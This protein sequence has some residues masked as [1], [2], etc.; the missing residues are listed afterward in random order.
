ME[1][2]DNYNKAVTEL[3]KHL[4]FT[5]GGEWLIVDCSM[6]YWH[7]APDMVIYSRLTAFDRSEAFA[8]RLTPHRFY[9]VRVFGG[10]KLTALITGNPP[11]EMLQIFDNSKYVGDA[12]S[13]KIYV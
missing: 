5:M 11:N 1:L 8:S 9:D 3:F 4:K 7:L 13:E 12:K 6:F 2:L 10:E